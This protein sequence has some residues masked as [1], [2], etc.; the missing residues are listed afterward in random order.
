MRYDAEK[1][2]RRGDV[3]LTCDR[4]GGDQRR[5]IH[6]VR[7][8]VCSRSGVLMRGGRG[9]VEVWIYS[10]Y[11]PTMSVLGK[12]SLRR[13]FV[14]LVGHEMDNISLGGGTMASDRL[15]PLMEEGVVQ[16]THA[17]CCIGGHSPYC[18]HVLTPIVMK[19]LKHFLD[20]MRCRLVDHKG[21]RKQVQRPRRLS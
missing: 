8:H 5:R 2:T 7:D 3:H 17:L 4:R 16:R 12:K 20:V 13:N 10:V 18:L 1:N 14:P 15:F 19:Y 11:E 6:I 9:A 21:Q